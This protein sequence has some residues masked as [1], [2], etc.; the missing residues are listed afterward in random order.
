[1][2]C[3]LISNGHACT[4]PGSHEGTHGYQDDA[5]QWVFWEVPVRRVSSRRE[6]TVEDLR[7]IADDVAQPIRLDQGGS[8]FPAR[9]TDPSTSQASGERNATPDV[10]RFSNRA[11]QAR[12]LEAFGD[13]NDGLTHFEAAT[14][15]LGEG[16]FH[17][18]LDGCRR[19]CSDLRQAGYIVDSGMRRKNP[20][21][22]DDSIVWVITDQGRQALVNLHSTG[23]SR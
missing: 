4:I 11:R 21:S 5:G 13:H 20:G 8:S 1:M 10:G 6:P 9:A 3:E 23:W 18:R 15:V 7:G 16:E 14:L 12:L 2:S 22:P 19:R 17:T